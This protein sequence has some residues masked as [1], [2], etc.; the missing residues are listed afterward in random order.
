MITTI[1]DT[2]IEHQDK[3][4]HTTHIVDGLWKK[5]RGLIWIP[6]KADQLQLRLCIIAHTGVAGYRGIYI[7]ENSLRTTFFWQT[8]SSDVRTFVRNCIH[9]VSTTE[10]GRAPRP[11]GP[12]LHGVNPNALLLL[13]YL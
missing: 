5:G 9:C 10:C 6:D 13:D 3:N 12:M 8:L 11:F 1:L 2:Q 4:P 7:S